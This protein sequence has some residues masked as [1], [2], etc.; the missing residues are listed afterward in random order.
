MAASD[1]V[2]QSYYA[3]RAEASR[4]CR[5]RLSRRTF[6]RVMAVSR[7][8]ADVTASV[9]GLL[10]SIAIAARVHM[11][12]ASQISRHDSIA[13]SLGAGLL[14]L[15]FRKPQTRQAV[16]PYLMRIRA[17]EDAIRIL[18]GILLA[19]MVIG[20]LFQIRGLLPVIAVAAFA[21][22]LLMLIEKH[23]LL[24]IANALRARGYGVDRVVIQGRADSVNHVT[25]ILRSSPWTGLRIVAVAIDDLR[26][27]TQDFAGSH[28]WRVDRG[29]VTASLLE[30]CQAHV[31]VMAGPHDAH[32]KL[33]EIMTVARCTNVEVAVLGVSLEGEWQQL[34]VADISGLLFNPLP[35]SASRVYVLAKRF[36]DIAL[37]SFLLLLFAPVM[38]LIAVAVCI[39]SSGRALFIQRRVG[40][41]GKLFNILKF[42]SMHMNVPCYDVSPASSN[43][44]RITRIGK[45]LRRTSL[46]ELPQ[47]I[48]VLVGDMSLVGP[49]PE[50]PFIVNNYDVLQRRRLEV[51]PGIT[52]LWQI[53]AD[54][55]SQIHENLHYDLAYIRHRTLCMDIAILVHTLF[56]AVRGV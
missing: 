11:F 47:L 12:A 31:L 21:I 13:L 33:R 44:R 26:I 22:P 51:V 23:G 42:R 28:H 14:A 5:V 40:L 30:S 29:P 4:S 19:L 43:D 24:S 25:S 1:S 32:E 27:S 20:S 15:L 16:A 39:D 10:A 52:G 9:L 48:N 38:F 6:D 34:S 56:F 2:A 53:S 7:D 17:T 45:F 18:T 36:M 8:A 35:H 55:A 46:D 41:D 50:M 37:S 54:R 49:R 3:G